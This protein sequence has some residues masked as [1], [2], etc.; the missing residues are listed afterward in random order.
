MRSTIDKSKAS[1]VFTKEK[2][3]RVKLYVK[4]KHSSISSRVE[5]AS[6]K[7]KI[8]LEAILNNISSKKILLSVLSLL[9]LCLYSLNNMVIDGST[10]INKITLERSN[11][12][13]IDSEDLIVK[14]VMSYHPYLQDYFNYKT[15]DEGKL[16]EF[17]NARNS[18]LAEEP[19]FSAIIRASNEFNLN[20]H[21][22]FAIT[23]QEQSFVPKDNV[24][25]QMIANNPF[26]VFHSW[27]EYNTDIYDSS[28]IA[29]RTVINLAKDKPMNVDIF[30]WINSKYAAD[31]NWGKGVKEIF[32]MLSE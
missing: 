21:I 6:K 1:S 25:A 31:K 9:I 15:I 29:A 26:N 30:D 14:D 2:I 13:N 32:G 17:L 12:S 3:K 23:G 11:V 16:L 28:R 24:N 10:I 22:L 7:I 27:Q 18:V 8:L 4:R 19:Y 5:C 20:P